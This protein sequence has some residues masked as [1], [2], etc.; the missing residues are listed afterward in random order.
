MINKKT[1]S[2]NLLLA[3]C[4]VVVTVLIYLPHVIYFAN[5]ED[6]YGYFY[7][8]V[9]PILPWSVL[10]ICLLFVLIYFLPAKLRQVVTS[11]LFFIGLFVWVFGDYFAVSYGVLD[12]G[13]IN[14][15]EFSYR[16]MWELPAIIGGM[17]VFAFFSKSVLKHVP[18][19]A[20][21]I[22]GGQLMIVSY[23]A[24]SDPKDKERAVE[25][26]EEFFNFSAKKNVILI[27]LDTFGN[28]YFQNI[29][30]VSP[31][32]KRQYQGFVNY[33]DAIS[34]YPATKGSLP[35]LIMG[36]MIPDDMKY[37]DYMSNQVAQRGLPVKMEQLGYEVSVLSVYSWFKDFY[38][39]RYMHQ[40]EVDHSSLIQLN[41]ANL[42]DYTL[43]R[44]AP[45]WYKEWVY[46][47][48]SWVIA[49]KISVDAQVPNSFSEK[50]KYFL[51][52]FKNKASVKGDQPRFKVIHVTIPHP[53][54]VYD[55]DCNRVE[56]EGSTESKMFKQSSC[57]LKKLNEL[58]GK[59]KELGVYDKSVIVVASDHGARVFDY[60]SLSGI[61]SYFEMGSS[62][63]LLMMKGINQ[64]APFSEI[65]VPVSLLS[66]AGFIQD[67][68]V[69]DGSMDNLPVERSR[70]FNAYRNNGM[71]KRGYMFN[72]P[73]Y[74]VSKDASNPNSWQLNDYFI[75]GCQSTMVPA[76]LSFKQ[77]IDKR[78][79]LKLGFSKPDAHGVRWEGNDS[80]LI[81]NFDDESQ[82]SSLNVEI[83]FFVK[84]GNVAESYLQK[85]YFNGQLVQSNTVEKAGQYEVNFEDDEQILK[86]REFQEIKVIAESINSS[87]SVDASNHAIQ[88]EVYLQAIKFT[89]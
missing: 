47:E 13:G 1:I 53:K 77:D 70:L 85:W 50:G 9:L 83:E 24:I 60:T 59:L 3:L 37:R 76:Q 29:L 57:A 72:A 71:G 15:D 33:T 67:E 84:Q 86:S 87:K 31:E 10:A 34:N 45:H 89:K 48:G 27:V 52:L 61:P 18:F 23:V 25:Y 56:A 73:Q 2:F 46:N 21:L 69:H 74:T 41:R 35:S 26:D 51:E 32:L 20:V 79:C 55:E 64:K 7:Q 80:R 11:L 4:L 12:G 22:I 43:F 68:T 66:L 28:E 39:K 40:P 81:F 36:E 49:N 88:N 30:K 78:N 17:V 8:L 58:L 38:Q 14:F 19:I 62:G 42:F 6:F 82:K 44:M 65:N 63:I 54:Y 5:R 16:N 75:T